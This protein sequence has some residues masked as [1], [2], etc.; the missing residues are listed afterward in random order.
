MSDVELRAMIPDPEY[1]VYMRR[2]TYREPTVEDG[3]LEAAVRAMDNEGWTCEAHEPG[4]DC[5]V[6]ARIQPMAVRAIVKAWL[7]MSDE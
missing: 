3:D 4:I 2:K 1:P 6:C 5:K 7:G